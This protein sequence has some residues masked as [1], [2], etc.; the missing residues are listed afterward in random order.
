M[1]KREALKDGGG[2]A[3][4]GYRLTHFV[5]LRHGLCCVSVQISS[6]ESLVS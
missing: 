4:L 5:I 6:Q 1:F 2:S 3:Y